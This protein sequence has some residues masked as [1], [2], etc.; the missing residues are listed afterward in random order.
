MADHT[1]IEGEVGE[2]LCGG[3]L[4]TESCPCQCH[5]MT[6]SEANRQPSRAW[7]RSEIER[8]VNAA[9]EQATATIERLEAEV[10]AEIPRV[11][12]AIRSEERKRCARIARAKSIRPVGRLTAAT[13]DALNIC[14]AHGE[15]IARKIEEGD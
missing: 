11:E 3:T 1:P 8:A 12:A 13:I 5:G 10:R 15:N 7:Y 9:L 2:R 14:E 4:C 6:A